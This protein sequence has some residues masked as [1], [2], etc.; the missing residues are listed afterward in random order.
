MQ[1]LSVS[2]A[3]LSFIAALSISTP[4][5]AAESDGLALAIVYDTSGSMRDTVR[6]DQ[7]K[8]TMKYL[9]ANRAL[10][11]VANQIEAYAKNQGGAPRTVH[12]AL[13]TFQGNNAQAVIPFGPF[14]AN[15][16]RDWANRFA[17]PNGATPLG[18]AIN[19]ATKTVLKSPL[20]R[21][22]ILVVTDGMN[23]AG[24][25]PETLLPA[26]KK[27]A[28]QQGT[29]FSVHFVAFDVDAKIFEPVKKLDATVVSAADE[30]QL[31]TQLDYI[32]QQKI[33]L[34]DEEPKK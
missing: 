25:R 26:L 30:K 6:D 29:P 31:N 8:Q 3:A 19:V 2:L 11:T 23:T 18:N 1:I 14:D 10:A 24:P 16:I 27:Q 20:S 28:T 34:E 15:A 5:A 9:I 33:L 21:K 17:N 32:L 12:A 13:Y 22:H 4:L 7:G